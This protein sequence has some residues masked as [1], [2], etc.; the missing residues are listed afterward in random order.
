M[1]PSTPDDQDFIDNHVSL[2]LAGAPPPRRDLGSYS[3]TD[4]IEG[5]LIYTHGASGR[6]SF[7]I[8]TPS[9]LVALAR[10]G[11]TTEPSRTWKFSK[12][13]GGTS[14]YVL[15]G[16]KWIDERAPANRTLPFAR[17]NE[18]WKTRIYSLA[19]ET[20]GDNVFV[21]WRGTYAATLSPRLARAATA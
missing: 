11:W 2:G 17:R 10:C 12:P 18:E 7:N 3:A 9:V 16:S 14:R 6:V 13:R 21:A 5:V 8:D 19:V 4:D 20:T 1:P 15:R